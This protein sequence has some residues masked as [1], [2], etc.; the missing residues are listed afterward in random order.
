[1]EKL[2]NYLNSLTPVEQKAFAHACVTTAGYLRKACSRNQVL[3][4]ALSVAIERESGGA[5]TRRDL[6]PN[7]WA[8][9][10]PELAEALG[11]GA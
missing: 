11:A 9:Q 7:S 8:D 3:G 6:H 4:P 1:M 10:W 5:V 2:L